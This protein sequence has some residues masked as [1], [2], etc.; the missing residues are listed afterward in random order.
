MPTNPCIKVIGLGNILLS[1]EG[2]GVKAIWELKERYTFSPEI[3][4]VD[5]GT[6][7]LF[8]L[9]EF[10]GVDKL[11]IIDAISGGKEPG[12]IYSFSLEELPQTVA[13]KISLHEV[14][15][16]DV[17]QLARLKGSL[18][19]EVKLIGM[20]PASLEWGGELTEVVKNKLS[21]LI[22]L[23]IFQLEKWGVEVKPL[24]AQDF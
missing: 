22:D 23:V 11:L 7:G 17:L 1:D 20:E 16:L 15:L 13:E 12:T 24:P 21:E 2:L 3:E 14:S 6:G 4:L 8:L 9:S 10:E 5:G 18:P 19:K